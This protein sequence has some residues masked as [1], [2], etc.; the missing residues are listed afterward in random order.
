MVDFLYLSISILKKRNLNPITKRALKTL[1]R[2]IDIR[3]VE[4]Q[5]WYYII[6]F[7]SSVF[8]GSGFHNP[9]Y[10][11]IKK[12]PILKLPTPMIQNILI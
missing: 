3:E 2:C 4:I 1:F 11:G 12:D 8:L 5:I 10:P 7:N 9:N 6:L